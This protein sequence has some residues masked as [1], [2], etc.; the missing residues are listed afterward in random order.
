MER[1]VGGGVNQSGLR[2]GY[3]CCHHYDDDD[4]DNEYFCC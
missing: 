3:C 1:G 4:D 2:L